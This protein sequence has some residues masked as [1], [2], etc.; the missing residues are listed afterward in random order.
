MGWPFCLTNCLQLIALTNYYEIFPSDL[1]LIL[2]LN[3][4]EKSEVLLQSCKGADVYHLETLVSSP[5]LDY[6]EESLFR[7]SCNSMGMWDL[8]Y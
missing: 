7:R 1:L 2:A 8:T 5:R 4:G 3:K 6:S